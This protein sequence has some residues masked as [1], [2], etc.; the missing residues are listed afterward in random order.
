MPDVHDDLSEV[1]EKISK[2]GRPKVEYDYVQVY[3]LA[4]LQCTYDEIA[5]FLNV[6]VDTIKR[7][8]KDDIK[9]CTAIQKGREK[10]KISLRRAQYNKAVGDGNPALLIWLGKQWLNQ[11]D[12]YDFDFGKKI[13]EMNDDEL[14][15]YIERLA[16]D[17]GVGISTGEIPATATTEEPATA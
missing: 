16:K 5:A 12:K 10:G 15:G 9:F 2:G 14:L 17:T 1:A 8:V 13:D 6:S 7:R 11:R 3:K 4:R